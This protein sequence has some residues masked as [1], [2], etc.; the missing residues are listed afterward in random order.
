MRKHDLGKIFLHNL[1]KHP[2]FVGQI[3]SKIEFTFGRSK[4]HYIPT[5]KPTSSQIAY[6][7]HSDRFDTGTRLP[8][9]VIK[10]YRSIKM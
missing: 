9:W 10:S 8:A 7:G 5:R 1:Y 3:R 2:F 4:V 6:R